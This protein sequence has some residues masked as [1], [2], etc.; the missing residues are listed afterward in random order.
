MFRCWRPGDLR[1]AVRYLR[2]R[3]GGGAFNR[4]D[5][6]RVAFA[7]K[8]VQLR[9]RTLRDKLVAR[10]LIVPLWPAGRAGG[11]SALYRLAADAEDAAE[12]R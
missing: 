6:L 5:L 9:A 12:D 1:M 2:S 8:G 4:R 3:H 10:E 7:L 11:R